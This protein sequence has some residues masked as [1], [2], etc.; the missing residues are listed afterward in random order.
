MPPKKPDPK[1]AK[2]QATE[3]PTVNTRPVVF[4]DFAQRVTTTP[5]QDVHQPLGR[6]QFEL[7]ADLVPHAAENV[8]QL[9]VGTSVTGEKKQLRQLEYRKSRVV[10]ATAEILQAGDVTG[11]D[12]GR[13]QDSI[14]GAIFDDEALGAIPHRAGTLSLANS[15]PNTNGSQFFICMTDCPHLDARH[16]SV[17]SLVGGPEAEAL[18]AD[19]HRLAL[20]AAGPYGRVPIQAGLYI[21][22]AGIVESPPPAAA[23][24]PPTVSP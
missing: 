16:V 10:R 19:L 1:G 20:A 22:E 18:L 3:A 7:R 5:G 14:Y 8:R 6:L 23:G 17:G 11:R 21:S 24:A 12:D 13:G 9:C 2:G 15:G 4:F